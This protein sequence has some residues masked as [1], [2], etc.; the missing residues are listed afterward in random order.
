MRNFPTTLRMAASSL[1]LSR[2]VRHMFMTEV[3]RLPRRLRRRRVVS[4]HQAGELFVGDRVGV[5]GDVGLRP[6]TMDAAAGVSDDHRW[7]RDL[8]VAAA[9][10]DAVDTRHVDVELTGEGVLGDARQRVASADLDDLLSGEPGS[11]MTN[12]VR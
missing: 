8:G 4:A 2:I 3:S 9:V 6:V 12:A 10:D 1:Q 7:R 5:G 11:R